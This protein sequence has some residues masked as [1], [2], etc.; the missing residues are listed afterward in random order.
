MKILNTLLTCSG[1]LLGH[2]AANPRSLGFELVQFY[3][4]YKMEFNSNLPT[5]SRTLGHRCTA[6][7]DGQLC[8]FN[9]FVDSVLEEG[10]L[11]TWWT[12]NAAASYRTEN[13]GDAEASAISSRA[14]L[15]ERINA[16]AWS[17]TFPS[18]DS[19]IPYALVLQDMTR[20]AE[21]AAT[22]GGL[23]KTD[24]DAAV[25][26]AKQARTIRERASYNF[27]RKAMRKALGPGARYRYLNVDKNAKTFGWLVTLGNLNTALKAN[28]I[29]KEQFDDYKKLVRDASRGILD[30]GN[31]SE[32]TKT[33]WAAARGFAIFSSKASAISAN[34]AAPPDAAPEPVGDGGPSCP[35]EFR[36]GTEAV[37][38]RRR[39][40]LEPAG[41]LTG[42]PS[43]FLL[44]P[45]LSFAR[46]AMDVDA[47]A[48][49]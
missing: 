21:Q 11:K 12:D 30:S 18:T 28:Q 46:G 29:T 48:V 2:V 26:Y 35:S 39:R 3:Y 25:S 45:R 40:R 33:H 38:K 22:A 5:E 17:M 8:P 4:V 13:P 19:K 47:V 34:L 15:R 43:L 24:V 6:E 42:E 7:I 32:K 1:V 41:G 31:T 10:D 49:Y 27:V 44:N 14:A 20:V 23:A 9:K 16:S 36:P 37:T